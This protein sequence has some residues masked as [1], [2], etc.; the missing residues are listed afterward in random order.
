LR[1]Y[2]STG[3]LV[4]SILRIIIFGISV[5]FAVPAFAIWRVGNLDAVQNFGYSNLGISIPV[6]ELY[7][8]VSDYKT[9]NGNGWLQFFGPVGTIKAQD[10]VDA[11]PDPAMQTLGAEE[12]K[13][14]FVEQNWNDVSKPDSCILTFLVEPAVQNF[15]T[16][17]VV[18]WAPG[19]GFKVSG[20]SG[21]NVRKALRDM[22]EQ[23]IIPEEICRW[24]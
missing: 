12:L 11:F 3:A 8:S 24:N 16:A 22:R 5:A 20:R 21:A 4:L 15:V 1:V 18:M 2:L 9:E 6:P 19:Q 14:F 23:M 7:P 17:I 10:F 13:K